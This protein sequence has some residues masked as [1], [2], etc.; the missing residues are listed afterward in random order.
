[1]LD[2]RTLRENLEGIKAACRLRGLALTETI[3]AA[4]LADQ[5]R[6][7]LLSEAEALR[8]EQNEARRRLPQSAREGM[9]TVPVQAELRAL[10]ERIGAVE[11]PLAEVQERLRAL[12][13]AIPNLVS[14]EVPAVRTVLR[15]TG[16]RTRFLWEPKRA[17]RLL[18]DLRLTCQTTGES[19]ALLGAGARLERAIA[20]YLLDRLA[21]AGCREL[22]PACDSG[23]AEPFF[24]HR[25]ELLEAARLPL[26][27]SELRLCAGAEKGRALRCGEIGMLCL[28]PPD[29]GARELFAMA[30]K[31]EAALLGLGLCCRV[32]SLPA[33]ELSFAAARS[34]AIEAWMP[35]SRQYRGV[36]TCSDF[37]DYP[38]RA[39][40]CRC[41]SADAPKPRPVEAVGGS[42]PLGGVIAAIL[43]NFQNG[44]GSV[45]VPDALRPAMGVERI[46]R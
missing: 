35:A 6:R 26:R 44:D 11:A 34:L 32:V 30:E 39:N 9:S 8:G 24:P 27:Y 31:L 29:G 16:E 15:Q 37:T 46:T 45:T 42:L 40:H 17:Q 4:L 14:R 12:L 13:S 10:A 18:S 28:V 19:A 38:A 23:G 20:G 21:G 22:S 41:K 33:G 2:V 36:C 43:E 3:D 25:G 5:E 1:M 7:A